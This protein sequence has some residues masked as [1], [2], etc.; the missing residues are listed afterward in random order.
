MYCW[1]NWQVDM[2][3]STIRVQAARPGSFS[4][5]P[6]EPTSIHVFLSVFEDVF[7]GVL[8]ELQK[9]IGP[10]RVT[11]TAWHPEV[12]QKLLSS[13]LRVEAVF[14]LWETIEEAKVS[15]KEVDPASLVSLDQSVAPR[16]LWEM[17]VADERFNEAF[18]GN[19][20]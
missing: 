19:D 10:I 8:Q 13:E 18:V 6:S 9:T 12:E 16:T 2:A 1:R 17:V 15:S 11:A 5:G 20:H 14:R 7:I 3:D 4:L